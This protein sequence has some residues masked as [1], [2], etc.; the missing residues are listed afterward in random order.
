MMDTHDLAKYII[1]FCANLGY[2]VSNLKLQKM[3]Y[4]VWVG[5]YKKTGNVLYRDLIQ[6][7]DLGPVLPNIYYD[8]CTYGGLPI[9][10]DD[11]SIS[12]IQEKYRGIVNFDILEEVIQQ[13]API[14]ARQLVERS[15]NPRGA[16]YSVYMNGLGKGRMIDYATIIRNEIK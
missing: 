16:W 2:S 8:Y 6:A 5:Y 12:Q 9:R 1:A 4:Y 10:V 3:L 14:S 13:L 15:H 7:W 11:N